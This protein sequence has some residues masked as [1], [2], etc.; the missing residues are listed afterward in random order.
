[1]TYEEVF[2]YEH[3][4]KAGNKCC[5]GVR[6]KQS[7][8]NFEM[9]MASYIYELHEQLMSGT[10]KSKG[11]NKFTIMFIDDMGD[12]RGLGLGSEVYQILAIYYPNKID[13][14]IKEQLHIKGYGRYM[15]DSY[16]IHKD[17]DY[18]RYCKEQ[19]EI[20][21]NEIGLEL[22]SRSQIIKLTQRF[23]FLKKRW[24]ITDNGKVVVRLVRKNI[25]TRRRTL[26]RMT[27]NNIDTTQSYKSW[28]GYAKHYNSYNSIL[29]ME[30]L[31]AELGGAK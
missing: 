4:F 24:F 13:H 29:S 5:N 23:N 2:S 14:F 11:F 8:Q 16:I 22:N 12:D 30:K 7:T 28:K 31:Y 19:I 21:S 27:H 6:W 1:M 18:L 10:Y 3:L 20:K 9:N 25:T 15:D 26:K 17:T